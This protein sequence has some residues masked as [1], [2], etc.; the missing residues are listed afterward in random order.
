[1]RLTKKFEVKRQRLNVLSFLLF[2]HIGG[3]NTLLYTLSNGGTL[4]TISERNPD[5]V[6]S[7][8]ERYRVELL[9][10][11]PTFINLILLSEAYK[12]HNLSSLKTITYG[13]EVMPEQV[14]KKFNQLLPHI[15]MQQTYGLS[16][17][18][19]LRSKSEKSDSLWVKLGGEGF[20]IRIVNGILQIKA[21]SAMLG[22]LNAPNPFTDDGWFDTGD[23]AEVNG[24]YIKI[25]GRKSDII[26]VGGEKV[27]PAEVESVILELEDVLE[28]VVFGEKNPIVSNIV[29]VKIYPRSDSDPSELIKR[30]KD[31]CRSRLQNFK[32]PVKI[33]ISTEPLHTARFKKTSVI[34]LI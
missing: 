24:E 19:I 29:C 1:V 17:L 33:L 20:E 6:L 11:S 27:Y 14:L 23:E 13:T 26:N 22:Y 16:E 4:I 9:P 15:S 34:F 21:E 32:V 8:I 28:V 31:H 10:T 5:A 2:D 18:G 25:L 12:R 3:L 30:I 7:L